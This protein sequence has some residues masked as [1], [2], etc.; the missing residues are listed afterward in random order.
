[1]TIQDLTALKEHRE[2]RAIE[3]EHPGH[4]LGGFGI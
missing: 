2:A 1:M 3:F 4:H